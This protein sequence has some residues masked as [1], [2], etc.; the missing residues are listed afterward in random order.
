MQSNAFQQHPRPPLYSA[1]IG[2]SVE[3]DWRKEYKLIE[4]K[5]YLS[6]RTLRIKAI[7]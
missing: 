3:A 4:V 7:G 6:V 5:Q 1:Q 2:G